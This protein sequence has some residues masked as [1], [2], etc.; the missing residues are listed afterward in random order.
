M[1]SFE[2]KI[3][4]LFD[5]QGFYQNP[6]LDSVIADT[7]K[8]YERACGYELSDDELELVSAAG[9]I[10]ENKGKNLTQIIITD[11]QNDEKA[12]ISLD[13]MLKNKLKNNSIVG[14]TGMEW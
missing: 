13:T 5:K 14:R 11:Y 2:K 6:A 10:N 12:E 3:G 1:D 9:D 7:E 4:G 8:R